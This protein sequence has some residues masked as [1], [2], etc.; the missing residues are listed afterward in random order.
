MSS[1][2]S[3]IFEL[4]IIDDRIVRGTA[5]F[6]SEGVQDAPLLLFVPG[7]KGF[8]DWG[9]W[10]WLTRSLADTGFV[11]VRIDLSMNGTTGASDRHDEPEKFARNTFS[12]DLEDLAAVLDALPDAHERLGFPAE[13]SRGP[14]G[15]I[16]HSRGGVVSL[17]LGSERDEIDA[18]ATLGSP[19]QG[20]KIFLEEYRQ[21]WRADGFLEIPNVRTGQVLRLEISILDDFEE[22]AERY[23]VERAV[24]V[25]PV[26]TLLVHGTRDETVPF[27]ASDEIRGWLPHPRSRREGLPTGHTFG[28][29]HPFAGADE[30][31]VAVSRLLAEFFRAELTR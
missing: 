31:G 29:V 10:P 26:P 3:Q 2:R 21:Q 6:P 16:G 11:T 14:I 1:T 17:L 9:G 18:V 28:F 22:N 7:F 20:Y 5:E 25:S 12:H 23:D 8:R 4:P 19:S 15:V 13:F 24:G 27:S 30:N